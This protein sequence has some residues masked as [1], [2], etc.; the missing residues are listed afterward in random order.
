[1]KIFSV[2]NMPYDNFLAENS[3]KL[4]AE[5]LLILGFGCLPTIDLVKEFN[6]KSD[7][8]KGLAYLSK[9][10]NLCIVACFFAKL[11]EK[12]Y[13]SSI[14]IDKGVIL[15]INDAT[16]NLNK[17]EFDVGH[18]FRIYNTS[19]GRFGIVLQDDIFFP[20]VARG[21]SKNKSEFILYLSKEKNCE[22]LETAL[23]YN[24]ICN[25]KTVVA[26]CADGFLTVSPFGEIGVEDR[27]QFAFSNV[28][29]LNNF[30]M[31]RNLREEIYNDFLSN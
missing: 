26:L 5:S 19:L 15:G 22:I 14:C 3:S 8:I 6:A 13:L 29:I 12:T 11:Y 28:K 4:E 23:K 31:L 1:M 7:V 25:G 9:A 16:H 2:C 17:A 20:E 21:I 27:Q 24:A 18:S 30:N 10:R